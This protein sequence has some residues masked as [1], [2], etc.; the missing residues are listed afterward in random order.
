MKKFTLFI[1]LLFLVSCKET[2]REP[3]GNTFYFQSP[4]P[5]NDSEVSKIPNG[6]QGLFM[7]S[8]SV[9]FEIKENAILQKFINRFR[10]HNREFDSIK[11]EFQI[12]NNRYVSKSSNE[13]Y[14]RKDIG[15]S[16]QF[17]NTQID[18]FFIFSNFQKAKRINGRLILNVKD[19]IYWKIR[20]LTLEKNILK[21]KYIYSDDDLKRMD[22]ITNVKSQMIDTA[23]YVIRPT[24]KEFKKILRLKNLGE[25]QQFKVV[26]NEISKKEL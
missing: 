23:T 13:I 14:F 4:Q 17:S 21:L 5:V 25:E 7:N 16:I 8:D 22:S 1:A 26:S 12:S 20:V 19:S 2:V 15:D 10:I 18:T 11:N 24:R 3:L 6:F 9:Y